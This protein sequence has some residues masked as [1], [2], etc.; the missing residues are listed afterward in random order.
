MLV[1]D[2]VVLCSTVIMLGSRVD[3]NKI[4]LHENKMG[5]DSN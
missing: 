3:F 4:V 5:G 2:M 1:L